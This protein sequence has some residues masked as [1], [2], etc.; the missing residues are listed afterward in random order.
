MTDAPLLIRPW[1]HE[2]GHYS[3]IGTAAPDCSP[4]GIGMSI[5]ETLMIHLVKQ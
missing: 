4:I 1:C 5:K 2:E 3:P